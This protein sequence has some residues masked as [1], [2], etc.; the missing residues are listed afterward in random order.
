[1]NREG[2]Y[3]EVSFEFKILNKQLAG[4]FYS[5]SQ[6]ASGIPLDNV[7]YSRD[8]LI[9]QLMTEPV[10]LFKCK[11]SNDS[12]EGQI[13]QEGFSN[14]NLALIKSQPP[15]KNFSTIDTSFKSKNVLIACRIYL[16]KINGKFPAVVFMHGSGGEGMFANQYFAEFLA[17]KGIVSLIQ[18]KRGVGKSTGDWKTA[19]FDDLANDHMNAINFLK[20]FKKVNHKQIGIYG[21]SQGGTIAPLVASKS[22]D[23]AFVIAASG[24]GDTIFKQDL[25]RTE[26]DLKSNGFTSV[27]VQEA[28]NYYKSWL[29]I[30]KTGIGFEKLDSLNQLSKNKKW[31]EWVEAPSKGHW[32]WKFYLHIGNFNSLNYW[33]MIKI[34]VFLIYGEDDQ[35]E[36]IRLYIQNIDKAL[37]N[38]ANNKDLTQI[39]LPKAQHNLCVSP[40]KNEKFFWWHISPGYLDIIASWI[41]YRFKN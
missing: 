30:A 16:P 11:V 25:Y 23:I 1:M 3:M 13:I 31:F 29:E 15:I 41:L 14:G 22:K 7:T 35:I 38:Q 39:I 33:K 34:P 36:D 6:R 28:I 19:N 8:S 2:E 37:I 17:S 24:I 21:H 10:S 12:I 5:S 4:F 18:D 20:K 40:E 27:E 26:N 9:F 32:L